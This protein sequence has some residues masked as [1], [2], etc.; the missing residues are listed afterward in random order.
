M[1]PTFRYH[2]E[3]GLELE[4]LAASAYM[5]ANK[6]AGVPIITYF[7]HGGWNLGGPGA[8]DAARLSTI[9]QAALLFLVAARARRAA[10]E[11]EAQLTAGRS[12]PRKRARARSV[13]R[14]LTKAAAR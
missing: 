5:V 12:P 8:S 3:R 9:I 13:P 10:Q 14:R 2:A 6:L 1:R 11:A 4:S 7:G